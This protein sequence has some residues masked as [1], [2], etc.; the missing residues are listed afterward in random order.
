[1][2]VALKRGLRAR[3]YTGGGWPGAEESGPTVLPEGAAHSAGAGLGEDVPASSSAQPADEW[4]DWSWIE[5]GKSRLRGAS[6]S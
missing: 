5:D 3:D 2:R 1:V 6:T 4:G